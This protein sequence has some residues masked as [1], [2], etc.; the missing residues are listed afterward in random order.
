[1]RVRIEHASVPVLTRLAT[2]PP[3]LPF[4]AMLV[5]ILVGSWVGGAVGTVLIG[6]AALVVAWLLYLS[7]PRLTPPERMMR[8]A[9]LALV[10]AV[11]ITRLF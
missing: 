4:L 1:M 10:V 8:L 11:A 3:W 9:V 2:L 6:L 5:L 7:W